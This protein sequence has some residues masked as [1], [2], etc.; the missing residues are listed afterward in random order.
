MIKAEVSLLLYLLM[1]LY[2]V[3][4]CEVVAEFQ[5]KYNGHIDIPLSAKGREDA[6]KLAEELSTIRFD[7]AFCSDLLRAKQT[8]EAFDLSCE[9][10]YTRRLR[11]KSWGRH[12]G[13]GFEEITALGIR[14][15]TFEQWISSLDGESIESYA[16]RLSEYF[17]TVLLK[18]NGKNLLVVT[19]AGVIKMLL[20]IVE[21]ID[22]N[23]AFT[24]PLPYSGY[25]VFDSSKKRFMV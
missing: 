4:H 21:K 15:E 23:E 13:M 2:F 18:Q 22:L 24:I 3:R 14:Y 17:Y 8:I 1:L 20:S 7:K 12:E 19:H 16:K 25:I 5:N 10:V 9:I 6:V 11:E